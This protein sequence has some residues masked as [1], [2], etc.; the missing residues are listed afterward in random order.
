MVRTRNPFTPAFGGRPQHFFGRTAEL[1]MVNDALE[2]DFSPYRALF[3]TG[4]RGCGK[5]SMLEQTSER[6]SAHR[7]LSVDVHAEDALISTVK[8]LAGGTEKTISKNLQPQAAGFSAG[9]VATST[10]MRYTGIDLADVMLER[11]QGAKGAQGILVSVDEVQKISEADAEGLCAGFQMALRKGFPVMLVMA[12]LPGSKEKIGSYRGCTFM[13]RAF[14]VKLSSLLVSETYDAFQQLLR[15]MPDVEVEEG[16]VHRLAQFS[17]GYPY[18]MQ[19][20]GYYAVEQM[21]RE[22]PAGA[23]VLTE[24]DVAAAE[25]QA[26]DAYRDNVLKAVVSPLRNGTYGYLRAAAEALDRSGRASTDDVASRLG[27]E[28]SQCSMDRQRLIDRRLIVADGY[29][30]VRFNMPYLSRYLLEEQMQ[31]DSAPRN[32]D[33]WLF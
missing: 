21:R 18:L 8:R 33:A 5:T 28:L 24:G 27:K 32:P 19:L 12:G 9:S 23:P 6:A 29:G 11:L 10:S 16:A 2:N 26:Y 1:A 20:I 17:M 22:R 14:E 13:Q 25:A 4:N 30:F 3:I 7:W 15:S 31:N